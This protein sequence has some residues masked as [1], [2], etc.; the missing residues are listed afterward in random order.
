MKLPASYFNAGT[1]VEVE[2]PFREDNN[3]SKTRP[4]VVMTYDDNV[5]KP[6]CLAC[7]GTTI[8]ETI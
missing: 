7:F 8:N 6:S 3:K 2:Y 4:A 1:I 5:T